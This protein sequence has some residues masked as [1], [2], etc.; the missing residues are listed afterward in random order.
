MTDFNTG[1]LKSTAERW[2]A[3]LCNVLVGFGGLCLLAAA[4]LTGLSIVGGLART[5]LPGEIELVEALCGFAVFA[6]MPYCQLMRGHVGVDL[7]LNAFGPKAMS[8]SQ[9][10]GDLVI[11]VLF[12]IVTWRHTIGFMDKLDNGETTTL[13]L[14]PLWWGYAVALVLLA[15]NMLI[16]LYA[17]ITDIGAIRHGQP[18]TIAPGAH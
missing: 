3:G 12:A 13:L 15:A 1:P 9:L 10:I 14:L 2:A 7:F 18:L 17:L 8:W 4:L 6:F 5:P 16:C 11:A